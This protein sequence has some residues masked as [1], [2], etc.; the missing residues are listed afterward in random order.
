M[1][2]D[3]EEVEVYRGHKIVIEHSLNAYH[4]VKESDHPIYTICGLGRTYQGTIEQVRNFIDEMYEK[5]T[6][7]Y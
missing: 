2:Y 7:D 1:S 6:E 4:G 5:Y 3:I